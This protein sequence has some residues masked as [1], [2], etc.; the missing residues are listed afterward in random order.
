MANLKTKLGDDHM[1]VTTDAMFRAKTRLEHDPHDPMKVRREYTRALD[2]WRDALCPGA[3][4]RDA[5]IVAYE[6]A[7]LELEGSILQGGVGKKARKALATK[8]AACG[9]TKGSDKHSVYLFCNWNKEWDGT[10]FDGA[11]KSID[12]LAFAETNIHPIALHD[13]TPNA[14]WGEAE[15]SAFYGVCDDVIT[16]LVNDKTVIVACVLGANRSM[17]VKYAI[18]RES[19]AQPQCTAMLRAA[20]AYTD[21]RNMSITPLA[22]QKGK[23][24]RDN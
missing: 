18:E 12:R 22:P 3:P 1:I 24:G 9:Y 6:Q 8:L 10:V 13:P 7:M 5:A 11:P 16:D 4:A 14:A 15:L 23:R 2:F 19:C 20:E 17:A 21:N